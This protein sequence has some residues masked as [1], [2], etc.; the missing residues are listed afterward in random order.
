MPYKKMKPVIACK[1]CFDRAKII[2]PHMLTDAA[3]QVTD[4]ENTNIEEC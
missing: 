3:V 2:A 4:N 1:R